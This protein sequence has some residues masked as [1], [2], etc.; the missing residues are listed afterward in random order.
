MCLKK[1]IYL[2]IRCSYSE[3]HA[4]RSQHGMRGCCASLDVATPRHSSLLAKLA[5]ACRQLLDTDAVFETRDALFL[6][7]SSSFQ[8]A[9]FTTNC[10]SLLSYRSHYRTAF[11][12]SSG[13]PAFWSR[14]AQLPAAWFPMF[15]ASSVILS[16]S[17]AVNER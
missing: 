14:N 3:S 16:F 11:F 7:Y 4:S 9:H 5:P 10:T 12:S 17:C 8:L 15:S 2:H 1:R 6:G 13:C